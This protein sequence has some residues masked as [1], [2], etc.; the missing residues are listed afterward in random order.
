MKPQP[1][2]LFNVFSDRYGTN[3]AGN[4][5]SRKGVSPAV[6]TMTGGSRQ[7]MIIEIYERDRQKERNLPQ[8]MLGRSGD[9]ADG[10]AS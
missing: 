10:S 5:W 1:I 4:V 9:D 6:L 8:R 2:R 3:Y 7:P